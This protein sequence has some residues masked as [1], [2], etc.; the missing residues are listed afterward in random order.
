[1]EPAAQ[2]AV[3]VG[4]GPFN[5]HDGVRWSG[6]GGHYESWFLRANH[7]REPKALWVRYTIFAPADGSP[8]E[9]ELWAIWFDGDRVVAGK[10]ELAIGECCFA[11]DRLEV[12]IGDATLDPHQAQGECRVPGALRWRFEL[13][14]GG[15]PLLLLDADRYDGGFPK[16][17][18]L[19]CA[20]LVR[21]RGTLEVEGQTIAIDDWLGSRNHNWGSRHT[22][23][24]AWTQVAGFDDRDDAMLEC[25]TAKLKLGPLWTPWMTIAVLRLGERTIRFTTIRRSLA[26]ASVQGLSHRFTIGN[27]RERLVVHSEGARASFVALRYRNPPG[28][29]KICLNTKIARA[30]VELHDADGSITRLETHGRA[31]LELLGDDAA[32][33]DPVA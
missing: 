11:R 24:Y 31:A 28:G 18:A 26:S 30:Q 16:A 15:S 13:H 20:P 17:K 10:R 7:P 6:R 32:G 29:V 9:G 33:F 25:I 21:I 12:R 3:I 23:R 1:M 19:V 14:G 22:D 27:G 5:P 2:R 4:D 8:A